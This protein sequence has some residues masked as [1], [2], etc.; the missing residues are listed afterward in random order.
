[1]ALAAWI[2]AVVGA[3]LALALTAGSAAGVVRRMDT[4]SALAVTPLPVL[5]VYFSAPALLAALRAGASPGG[6]I[7]LGGPAVIGTLTLLG[8]IASLRHQT[9]RRR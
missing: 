7:F 9:S 6:L 1:M 4:T 2:L 5:A 8:V 3:G